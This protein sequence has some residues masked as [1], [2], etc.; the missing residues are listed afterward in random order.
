MLNFR[1]AR[2]SVHKAAVLLADACRAVRASSLL[3]KLL[4]LVVDIGNLANCEFA[5]VPGAKVNG[6][7]IS[8][9]FFSQT[10]ACVFHHFTIS[11]SAAW[12]NLKR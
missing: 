8:R 12:A 7:R 6:I 5:A 9:F 2:D 1:E 3:P 11:F 4:R 10:R